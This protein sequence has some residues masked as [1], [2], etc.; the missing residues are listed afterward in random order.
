MNKYQETK[1]KY[2]KERIQKI[3]VYVPMGKKE[4]I[5]VYAKTKSMNDY[6]LELIKKI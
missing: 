3:D 4:K 6:I 1:N 2:K 5:Q